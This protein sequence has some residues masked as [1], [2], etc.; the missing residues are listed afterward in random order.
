MFSH[1]T[2]EGQ[3]ELTGSASEAGGEID[4]QRNDY[5]IEQERQKSKRL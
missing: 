2:A 3:R 5:R 1:K 4:R